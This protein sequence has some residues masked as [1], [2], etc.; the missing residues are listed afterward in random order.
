MERP[1]RLSLSE[2]SSQL[3]NECRMVLPG[4]QTLLLMWSM[5]P[6]ALG[7][8]GDVVHRRTHDHQGGRAQRDRRHPGA[9][10]LRRVLV[11]LA[12]ACAPRV[13]VRE[14]PEVIQR[15]RPCV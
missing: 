12:V 2:A 3:L 13:G 1:V 9:R 14:L 7:L 4:I 8:A 10:A 15:T 6:L 5:P 11:R